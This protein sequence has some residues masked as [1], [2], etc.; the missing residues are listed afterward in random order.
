MASRRQ[1]IIG[2]GA[3]LLGSAYL[4]AGALEGETTPAADFRIV[5]TPRLML[6]PGR[7]DQAYVSVESA[8]G[9]D[10][11]RS[12][13]IEELGGSSKTRFEGLVEV[14]NDSESTFDGLYFTLDVESTNAD[15]DDIE[16]A[17]SVVSL[18]SKI[19]A[20]GDQN[21]LK[22]ATASGDDPDQLAPEESV[23]FGVAIDLQP[24]NED[25]SLTALPDP[26]TFDL[27]LE[28]ATTMA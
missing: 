15:P 6:V 11:V 27:T 10:Q 4:T 9:V 13:T 3:V 5:A 8:D 26:D 12:I 14:I 18:S 1:I 21:F 28:L 17:I 22:H 24:V 2:G 25:S 7:A 20:T 19:P 16:G 23:E